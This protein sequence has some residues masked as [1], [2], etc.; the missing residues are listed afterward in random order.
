M[1]RITSD[2]GNNIPGAKRAQLLGRSGEE[3]ASWFLSLADFLMK[4]MDRFLFAYMPILSAGF[5]SEGVAHFPR[6]QVP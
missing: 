3:N 5:T 4:L 2:L 1:K 6:F